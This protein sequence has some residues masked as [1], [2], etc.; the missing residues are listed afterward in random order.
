MNSR[1][2]VRPGTMA[3]RFSHVPEG[4]TDAAGR[5]AIELG[6]SVGIV[7]DEWQ[8]QVLL[9]AQVERADHRW[10]ATEVGV[11]VPRQNGKNGILQVRETAGLVLYGERLQTHTAHRFDTALEHY[12]LMRDLFTN[13]DDLRRLVKKI[14]EGNGAESIELLSGQRLN[15]KAR[16]KQ[17]GRGFSGD[18][19]VF[20]EAFWL[21]ELGSMVPSLSARPNPQVWYT[22]SAPMP[23]DESDVLRHLMRRGRALAGQ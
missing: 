23:R 14:P 6:E 9:G 18:L 11:V 4:V 2:A 16:A 3:P 22:S 5:E 13:W 12:R 10:A 7:L 8:Q 17:G 21:Q 1:L 19:V 15:F 20:D